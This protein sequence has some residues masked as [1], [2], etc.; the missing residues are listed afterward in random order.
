MN[1][2]RKPAAPERNCSIGDRISE[3]GIERRVISTGT[4]EYD[5]GNPATIV[6]D[7]DLWSARGH[8]GGDMRAPCAFRAPLAEIER[9]AMMDY[10][11]G[12][13]GTIAAG[14]RGFD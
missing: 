11:D 6:P 13:P 5:D 2:I 9:D 4:V 7:N 3:T 12:N 10:D 8:T 14:A 1:Q